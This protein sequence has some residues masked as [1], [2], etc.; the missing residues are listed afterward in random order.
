MA[1][2]NKVTK[3]RYTLKMNHDEAETLYVLLGNMSLNDYGRDT[4]RFEA[5]THVYCALRS[6]LH[7]E[8]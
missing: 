6:V 1:K 4:K 8:D 5:G 2:A 3:T 7:E